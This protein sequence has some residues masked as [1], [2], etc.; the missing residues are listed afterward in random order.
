M[1]RH[2]GEP[3]GHGYQSIADALR[4][5]IRSGKYLPGAFLP[6]ERDLQLTFGVSRSTV[7]RALATLAESGWASVI[8]KRGVAAT[9]GSAPEPTGNVAFIDHTD[10]VNERVFFG[11]SRALQGSGL[12]LIHVDSRTHGVEGALEYSAQ[13]GFVAAFIWS[14]EGFPDSRRIGE[15]QKTMPVIALDH[16]LGSAKTDLISEDN[17]EGAATIVRHVARLGRRRIAISGMMDM[18]E[19]NHDRFSGYLKGLFECEL[20][21]HPIDFLFCVTSGGGPAE[22]GMLTRRF[23]D[24]DR[25]DAIFVL[26]DMCVPVVVE[27]I[28]DAGLR[29]PEDVAV[30]AFGGE[31]PIQIDD[32]GLTSMV[33]DWPKF[34]A[35]CVRVLRQR[36]IHPTNPFEEVLLTTTP[37]IRGSCGAP[38]DQWDPVPSTGLEIHLG[39]RWQVQQEYLQIR[40]DSIRRHP[41]T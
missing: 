37:V 5:E 23:L 41:V 36:L 11:I 10:M 18:L 39:S 29:I 3:E 12:H 40:S 16:T 9:L 32:V 26:Q 24:K 14:K 13:N 15:V 19:V 38:A 31:V 4:E 35:E 22:T 21:P 34:A 28:F 8:P 33:I 2:A 27:A 6:T 1:K 25:P 30:V 17:L 20:T 7:R